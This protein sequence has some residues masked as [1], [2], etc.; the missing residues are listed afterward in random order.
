MSADLTTWTLVFDMDCADLVLDKFL[1]EITNMML[2]AVSCIPVGNNHW[3][4][5]LDRRSF[6]PLQ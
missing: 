5:E 6:L 1:H 4:V 3:R 2:T